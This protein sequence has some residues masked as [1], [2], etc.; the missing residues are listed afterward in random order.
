[1]CSSFVTD[2]YRPLVRRNASERHY[3]WVSRFGVVGFGLALA[4]IAWACGPVKNVLWF[5][6]QVFSL[7]GGAVLGV[8]LLGLLTRRLA[9]HG[10]VIAMVLSTVLTT[11][12]MI[13]SRREIIP[14]AWSWLIV[15]GTAATFVIG[16]LLG[17][18]VNDGRPQCK[19]SGEDSI[20]RGLL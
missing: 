19:G 16:Y 15:V 7:T 3:L 5:A 4:L 8:F 6:F 10:N 1:M 14:L 20:R 11:A 17:R 9:N 13:A 18:P 2:I 12:L